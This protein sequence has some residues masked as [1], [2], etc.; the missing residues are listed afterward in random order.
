MLAANRLILWAIFQPLSERA[1]A[2]PGC[3]S[4]EDTLNAYVF[5]QVWPVDTLS[6]ADEA[7]VVPLLGRAMEETWKPRQRNR[8]S[9]PVIEIY[10][11]AVFC[12][13]N[14]LGQS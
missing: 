9:A 6:L 1:L 14:V 7:P 2:F 4:K 8:Y 12:D 5:V 11:Q 10:N 13:G 3:P